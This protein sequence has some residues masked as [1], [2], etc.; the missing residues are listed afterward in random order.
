MNKR[1][2]WRALILSRSAIAGI[3]KSAAGSSAMWPIRRLRAHALNW[4]CP[5]GRWVQQGRV[6]HLRRRCRGRAARRGVGPAP[7][8]T[9]PAPRMGHDPGTAGRGPGNPRS[10]FEPL[11]NLDRHGRVIYIGTFSKTML[12][13]LRLGFLVAPPTLR[14]AL[15]A[16]KDVTDWHSPLT[17][18]AALARF[19]DDGLLARHIR[20]AGPLPRAWPSSHCRTSTPRLRCSQA[21]CSASA[22]SRSRSARSRRGSVDSGKLSIDMRC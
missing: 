14:K 8:R 18:Q 15:R 11:Q 10:T 4:D 20:R 5:R 3:E 13:S 16:A 9:E 19:I 17:T 2:T 6:R 7:A 1:L 12:P 21:W 22:R